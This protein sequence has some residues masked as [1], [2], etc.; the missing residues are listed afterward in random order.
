MFS[1]NK[2]RGPDPHSPKTRG[3]LLK[4]QPK[5]QPKKEEKITMV[6]ENA[7]Y[8]TLN[9]AETDHKNTGEST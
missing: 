8:T 4:N 6:D 1:K 9:R 3:P 2:P 5:N 7:D